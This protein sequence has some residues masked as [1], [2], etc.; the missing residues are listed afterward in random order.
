MGSKSEV[1]RLRKKSCDLRNVVLRM[2]RQILKSSLSGEINL[3]NAF[4]IRP[5]QS[6]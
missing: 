3:N 1:K 2:Q 4:V 5:S 6:K